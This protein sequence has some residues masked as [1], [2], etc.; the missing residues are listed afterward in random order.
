MKNTIYE[1]MGGDTAVEMK[2]D[3]VFGVI[4]GGSW[5]T[6]LVKLLTDNGRQLNWYM[7]DTG[8]IEHIE[9][10]H[11]HSKYLPAVELDADSFTIT[12]DINY[13]VEESDILIFA[14][15]SAYFLKEV[16]RII[17]SY[18]GKLLI[19]AVKGFV[20]D[21]YLTIA[22]YFHEDHGVPFDRIGV[23]SGPCHAEEVGMQ[24]LSYITLSSKYIEVA[25]YL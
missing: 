12:N 23:I 16:S 4:G 19:S 6:A 8:A 21:R 1:K 15:P 25:E 9:R 20:G 2:D 17:A 22:E 13:V 3:P 18:D 24:R 5:A 10:Y 14:I 11:H 7:R